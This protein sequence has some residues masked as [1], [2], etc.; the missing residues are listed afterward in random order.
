MSQPCHIHLGYLATN[1]ITEWKVSSPWP[2]QLCFPKLRNIKHCAED[3]YRYHIASHPTCSACGHCVVTV[4]VGS[5]HSIESKIIQVKILPKYWVYCFQIKGAITFIWYILF[6]PK[7][8]CMQI[9]SLHKLSVKSIVK[10]I[11]NKNFPHI[12]DLDFL[13]TKT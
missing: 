5:A 10:G 12:K 7:L 11:R 2:Y 4:C 6:G 3:H 13:T 1:L 8:Q 9:I